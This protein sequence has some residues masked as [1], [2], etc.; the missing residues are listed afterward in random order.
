VLPLLAAG[1]SIAHIGG[2][3]AIE[4]AGERQAVDRVA[5]L[6]RWRVLAGTAGYQEIELPQHIRKS[7]GTSVVPTGN[8]LGGVAAA[9]EYQPHVSCISFAALLGDLDEQTTVRCRDGKSW[10][11]ASCRL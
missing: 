7:A 11:A 4:I 10:V 3:D 2:G 9:Q 8:P 6:G 5:K 1:N